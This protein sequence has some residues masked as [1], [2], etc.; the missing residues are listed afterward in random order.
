MSIR[1][2][3]IA[4]TTKSAVP[5]KLTKPNSASAAHSPT[6]SASSTIWRAIAPLLATLLAAAGC[7]P[8]IPV[9]PGPEAPQLLER[10]HGHLVWTEPRGGLRMLALPGKVPTVLRQ[11]AADGVATFATTHAVSGPDAEGRIVYLEDHFFTV[12]EAQRRH[13][14]KSLRIDGGEE[15]VV[16]QRSGS[17]LQGTGPAGLMATGRQL[18]LSPRGG[19]VLALREVA[20]VQLPGSLLHEGVL[21]VWELASQGARD[22][23]L[24]ALDL[25]LAWLPDGRRFVAVALL[26]R[27]ELPADFDG[28]TELG[29]VERSWPRLPVVVVGEVGRGIVAR[30]GLGSLSVVSPDGAVVWFGGAIGQRLRSWVRYELAG[31]ARRTVALPGLADRP[32]AA[33][34]ADLLLYTAWPTAGAEVQWTS[35]GSRAGGTP[36]ATIKVANPATKGFATILPVFDVRESVSFGGR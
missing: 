31:G 12:D 20:P 18:A 4:A 15:R 25:P 34:A 8:A 24:R 30:L 22:V 26:A 1:F 9:V 19:K 16:F 36:L 28:L 11:A 6:P 7:R 35:L 32:I 27:V 13:C 3:R 23:G 2:A 5:M 10:I 33:V 29:E 14:L 21:E 17:L